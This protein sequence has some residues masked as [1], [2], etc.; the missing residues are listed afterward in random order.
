MQER[1]EAEEKVY[2]GG[3]GIWKEN[4]VWSPG[5]FVPIVGLNEQAI[6]KYVRWEEAQDSDQAKLVL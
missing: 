2:M 5:Y 3:K 1:K 4:I 6:M